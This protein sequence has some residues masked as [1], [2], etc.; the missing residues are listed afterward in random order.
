LIYLLVSQKYVEPVPTINAHL[1]SGRHW[2]VS[3]SL[4]EDFWKNTFR[5]WPDYS[6]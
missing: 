3:G 2:Y 4:Q 6:K 1:F 5:E